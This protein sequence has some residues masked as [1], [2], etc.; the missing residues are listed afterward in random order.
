MEKDPKERSWPADLMTAIDD[1]ALKL[2][3]VLPRGGD[4]GVWEEIKK[5][6]EA[7]NGLSRRIASLQSDLD[8]LARRVD[9]IPGPGIPKLW[10]IVGVV[11][12]VFLVAI[13]CGMG[14]FLP[15]A[16]AIATPTPMNLATITAQI[17]ALETL[18]SEVDQLATR[19][20]DHQSQSARIYNELGWLHLR[21]ESYSGAEAMFEAAIALQAD[22]PS[23]YQGLGWAYLRRDMYDEAISAFQTSV[24]L[25]G[26]LNGYNGLGWAYYEMDDCGQA[27]PYF[28]HVVDQDPNGPFASSAREGLNACGVE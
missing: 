5:L 21:N 17:Q 27:V 22:S 24:D 14:S 20:D 7:V 18:P 2:E 19:S 11:I 26:S 28:R 4:G 16:S 10:G 1:L 15:P 9:E 6:K 13:A 25:G 12:T 8:R 3:I 23:A